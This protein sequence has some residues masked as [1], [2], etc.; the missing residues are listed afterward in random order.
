MTYAGAAA[1][2][3]RFP[4]LQNLSRAL[5][6]G[7]VTSEQLVSEA[8]ERISDPS[9]E[10][11]RTF[12]TVYP[13]GALA[14]ARAVDAMRREGM[15]ISP[16]A[17]IPISVKEA[18]EIAG[19]RMAVGSKVLRDNP[20][21]THDAAVV[22]RLRAA[23][24]VI[25][26][27]TNMTEL[28]FSTAGLN[29]HYG[30]PLNPYDRSTGRTPGG[31][32]SGA[33]VS[34]SDGM[35]AA[36]IASDTGGSVRVPAALC[37]LTGFKPTAHRVP[38]QGAGSLAR[39]LDS[40]GP[41]GW[42]VTCCALLDAVLRGDVE[43]PALEGGPALPQLRIGVLREY[44]E[45]DLEPEVAAAYGRA[46]SALREAGATLADARFPPMRD[47]PRIVA[48]GGLQAAEAYA[49]NRRF[50]P[51]RAGDYDP[52]IL[53]RVMRGQA[54]SAADYLE[55][56]RER[57]MLVQQFRAF[58][59]G[60]DIVVM[61]T[62]PMIA[63]AIAEVDSSDERFHEVQLRLLR[64]PSTV[65]FLDGCAITL[66]CHAPDEPPVGLSLVGSTG[67]DE[68]VLRAALA[69]ED[70]LARIRWPA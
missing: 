28:A 38:L 69:V 9:G 31:S 34:V 53:A 49:A 60:Y 58:M 2:E 29:P 21:A 65:N 1:S 36:A 26:G 44:V 56:V 70:A 24:L 40:A 16:L 35:A 57:Q 54:M 19:S 18:F 12:I 13:Q 30:T 63:P 61:P 15:S 11:P 59:R 64:N 3:E 4:T 66:P 5:R 37:G 46:L 43:G 55:V 17:G 47:I 41:I 50:L 45:D 52:R 25:V 20:P 32:S 39:L 14:M 68:A 8:L 27:R 62:V 6:N 22:R 67:S 33:A 10:G 7:T 48:K 42:T 51:S 23:G